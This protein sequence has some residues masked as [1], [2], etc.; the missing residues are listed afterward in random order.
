MILNIIS[1]IDLNDNNILQ[2]FNE[3]I[4]EKYM[5]SDI[6][7]TEKIFEELIKISIKICSLK[8]YDFES[9]LFFIK[10]AEKK[11]IK[12]TN[13]NFS[14][15]VAKNIEIIGNQ[16]KLESKTLEV[17]THKQDNDYNINKSVENLIIDNN[18][19]S[20]KLKELQKLIHETDIASIMDM[21][22]GIIV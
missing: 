11:F 10:Q 3:K 4:K 17:N 5:K 6:L 15:I 20:E 9:I 12:L 14:D 22:Q 1:E 19:K 21:E 13:E 8:K 18:Y 7:I 2:I 16:L